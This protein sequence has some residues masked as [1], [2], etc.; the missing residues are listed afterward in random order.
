MNLIPPC[1]AAVLLLTPGSAHAQDTPVPAPEAQTAE[2]PLF[3]PA[4]WTAGNWAVTPQVGVAGGYNDNLR[5]QPGPRIASPFIAVLPSL[6]VVRAQGDHSIEFG[7][8]SEW[9]SFV[10]SHDDDTLNSEISAAGIDLLGPH[11]AMTWTLAVQDWHD[12]LGLAAADDVAQSPDHFHA[13][14]LGVVLRHDTDDASTQRFEIEP[15]VSAKHYLNHRDVTSAADADTGSL[16]GRWLWL[17]APFRRLGPEVRVIRTRYPAGDEDL[18]NTDTR[19]LATVKFEAGGGSVIGSTSIGGQ[20]RH[21]DATRFDYNGLTW[22]AE[23]QFQASARTQFSFATS[24][25]AG[26]APGEGVDE[27]V[28]RRA[29]VGVGHDWSPRWHGTATASTS[30]N[31]YVGSALP[32]DDRVATLD[33]TLRIDLARDWRLSVNYG[34]IKRRSQIEVFNFERQ[35]SS[36]ELSAAL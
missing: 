10:R 26:E 4:A 36:I 5:L 7:W 12:A 30:D 27:V 33:F 3:Q 21:F 28:S 32:R 11:T 8:R 35:L 14:A 15:T 25:A 29:S 34:W 19:G 18:S 13:A 22:D 31:H 6:S 1:I 9:T 24:R 20:H 17:A 16:V 2:P 23:W